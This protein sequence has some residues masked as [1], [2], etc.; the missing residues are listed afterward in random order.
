MT[1]I[2]LF[3]FAL[4]TSILL[5]LGS[6]V[7]VAND[8][9]VDLEKR[10]GTRTGR[11][12][13]LPFFCIY[14]KIDNYFAHRRALGTILVSATLCCAPIIVTDRSLLGLGNCGGTD[15]DGDLI[16]AIGK[17]LYDRTGGSNCNQVSSFIH[18]IHTS[19]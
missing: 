13:C 7:P 1:R 5:A 10:Q 9:L 19:T 11:V 14:H 17:K 18:N 15:G 2:A 4:I 12:S 8:E 3:F 6:P 16:L